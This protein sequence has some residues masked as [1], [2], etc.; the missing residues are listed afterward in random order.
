LDDTAARVEIQNGWGM[1]ALAAR[2]PGGAEARFRAALLGAREPKSLVTVSVNLGQ[3]LLE[4]GRTLEASEAVRTAEAEAIRAAVVIKLPEVYRLLGDVAAA[5]NHED[6]FV[7]YERA[8]ELIAREGLPAWERP[9]TMEGYARLLEWAGRQNESAAYREEAKALR[10]RLASEE[11]VGEVRTR[12][13][14]TK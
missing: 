8:L 13:Q 1:L 3:A 4:Q 10:L 14:E 11:D 12:N 7:V 6:S 5:W 2:D 9:E